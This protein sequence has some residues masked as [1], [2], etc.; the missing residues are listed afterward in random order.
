MGVVHL[1][2]EE[3]DRRDASPAVLDMGM[4]QVVSL[5]TLRA[6]VHSNVSYP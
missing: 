2:R 6:D 3:E 1:E 4:G 5:P